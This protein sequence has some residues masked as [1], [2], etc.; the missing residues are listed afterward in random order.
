MST[1]TDK[2]DFFHTEYRFVVAHDQTLYID[3]VCNN[4][5]LFWDVYFGWC[6]KKA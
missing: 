6:I 2:E 4:I 3:I 5:P 1:E